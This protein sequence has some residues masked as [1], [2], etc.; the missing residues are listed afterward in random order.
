MFG[1]DVLDVAIGL[2]FVYLVLSLLCSAAC[3][4]IESFLKRRAAYLEQGLQTLLNGGTSSGIVPEIYNH[5]LVNSL[6]PGKYQ[7]GRSGN[8]PSYIPPANFAL[9]LMDVVGLSAPPPLAAFPDWMR[10]TINANSSFNPHLAQGLLAIAHAADYDLARTRAGIETWYRTAMDRVSGRFK[11]YS[12]MVV[13]GLGV[14][15]SLAINADTISVVNS[16]STGKALRSSLIAAATE[17]SKNPPAAGGSPDFQ[18]DLQSI[19]DA[20]LPLGWRNSTADPHTIPDNPK[21]WLF[22]ALGI[23]LTALAISLGAPFWFDTLNRI[24]VVRSAVKPGQ[25]S[26][27]DPTKTE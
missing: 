12:Q 26:A 6:F 16:L 19:R 1:S 17:A 3:E 13:L 10:T 23:V 5:P 9:A 18:A 4:L 7:P 21:A 14:A 22:K 27:A 15:L 20:G 8:L 11:R 2:V 25:D 24:I